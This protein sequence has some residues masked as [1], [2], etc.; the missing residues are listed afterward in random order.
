MTSKRA[1]TKIYHTAISLLSAEETKTNETKEK[2]LRTSLHLFAQNGYNAVSVSAIAGQLGIT[3]GALY[4]HYKNKRDIFDSILARMQQLDS[5]RAQE[6]DLPEGTALQMADKYYNASLQ[7]LAE[8][9]KAQFNYW[10]ED[11]FAAAFR[12][13]LS[14]EQFRSAEMMQLY[15]Q[16][17]VAGPL[18]YVTD[19]LRAQNIGSA[20]QKATALYSPMFLFYAVYDGADDKEAARALLEEYIDAFCLPATGEIDKEETQKTEREHTNGIHTQ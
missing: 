6:Y 8:F 4:R 18:G 12:R 15:Q 13:M 10:T 9:C 3:K 17:L 5:E 16:Y 20:Q 19:I 11:D 7:H 1:F 14:L 2:I